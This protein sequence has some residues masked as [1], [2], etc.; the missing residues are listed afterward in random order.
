MTAFISDA[1]QFLLNPT[2]ALRMYDNVRNPT[3]SKLNKWSRY[4]GGV[5][6]LCYDAV[7]IE[8]GEQVIMQSK[9]D[10]RMNKREVF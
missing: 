3:K 1:S 6:V 10:A 9:S 4:I 8:Q 7:S 5:R 2:H